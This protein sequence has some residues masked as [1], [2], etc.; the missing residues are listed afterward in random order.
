[1]SVATEAKHAARNPWVGRLGRFGLAAKGVSF[2]IV[3]VLAVLVALHARDD[4]KD[5]PGALRELGQNGIGRFLLI[6]LAVGFLA[7]AGWRF[8]QGFLDRDHE[9]IKPK[10]IGKRVTSVG[11]GAIYV[12]LFLSTM[13]VILEGA[14]GGEG[15]RSQEEEATS[16]VLDWPLGRYLVIA[17]GVGIG[18]VGVYNGYR[19]VTAKFRKKL[20]TDLMDNAPETAAVVLGVVGHA[21][22]AV[23]FCIAAWFLVKAAW[24]FDPEEA[25]G[26]D[27]ALATLAHQP[28]GDLMLGFTALGLFAYGVY[29]FFE[30]RYRKV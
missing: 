24:E 28:Y 18:V 7:Y 20:R 13:S 11:K 8:A 3:G 30:A 6:A 15:R 16:G 14:G 2:G 23:V 12:G 19:A 27:G 29:C 4:T 9:G 1:V 17:V 5:R 10:G 25:V 21:A 22:R 26:I